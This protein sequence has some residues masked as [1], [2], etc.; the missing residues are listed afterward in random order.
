MITVWCPKHLTGMMM[1]VWFFSQAASFAIGGTLANIAAIPEKLSPIATLP[2]Y[3]HAFVIYG[4]ISLA[5]AGISFL[6]IP[7]LNKMV[8]S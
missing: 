1:G 3:S 2:F 8:K 5:A 6:L 4:L 7:I